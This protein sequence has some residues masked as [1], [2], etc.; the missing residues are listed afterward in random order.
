MKRS[1]LRIWILGIVA[2]V[3]FLLAELP[4]AYLTHWMSGHFTS[5]QLAGISG[6]LFSGQADDLRYG[7]T[8]MGAVHWDFDWWAPFTGTL[9]YR[10]H[11]HAEDHDLQGRVDGGLGGL[12]LHDLKGRMPVAALDAWLPLPTNSL[13]GSVVLDVKQ[14]QL[15]AGKLQ[16]AEGRVELDDA[17]MHWPTSYTLGSFGM[18]LHPAEAGGVDGSLTDVAS[19]LKLQATLD[20]TPDGQYHLKGLLAARDPA[21][22]GTRNLLA[23][24]GRPDSTGQY[25]F[26]FKGQW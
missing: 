22:A 11:A 16:S 20:L 26:D 13:D 15:K 19:P 3:V 9:G 25:P 7:R 18:D 23:N 24:L 1:Q 12:H 14:L 2:Y 8:D 6:S 21:D 10:F 5:L 17:V 4:A